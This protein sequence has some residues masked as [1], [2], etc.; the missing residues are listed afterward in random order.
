MTAR[1][2]MLETIDGVQFKTRYH[3][4]DHMF[5]A[6][7]DDVIIA[8]KSRKHYVFVFVRSEDGIFD[9]ITDI[10]IDKDSPNLAEIFVFAK[11]LTNANLSVDTNA[12]LQ[13]DIE[14][15]K[16]LKEKTFNDF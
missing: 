15:S 11:G 3:M 5:I 10:R 9:C 4:H 16:R 8:V 12:S 13:F 2:S 1:I 7:N 6:L 14:R